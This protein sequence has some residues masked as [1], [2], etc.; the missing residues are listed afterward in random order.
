MGS[1]RFL[2][3]LL[4]SHEP[5]GD[6]FHRVPRFPSKQTPNRDRSKDNPARS[7]LP[8]HGVG[9]ATAPRR[10]HGPGGTRSL[11]RRTRIAAMN[12]GLMR[13]NRMRK[14]I[15][16]AKIVR[17][18]NPRLIEV[19]PAVES[20][21]PRRRAPAPRPCRPDAGCP[22]WLGGGPEATHGVRSHMR[23]TDQ[24]AQATAGHTS[25]SVPPSQPANS[26]PAD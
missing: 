11:P 16:Y 23:R 4:T 8:G 15:A 12:H 7:E 3:D 6:A 20:P 5:G 22:C 18:T 13:Q 19:F 10:S 17:P 24:P 26:R 1:P 9:P 14:T 25:R 2:P 21:S